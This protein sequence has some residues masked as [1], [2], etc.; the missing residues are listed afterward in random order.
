M[1]KVAARKPAVAREA[2]RVRVDHHLEEPEDS[3]GDGAIPWLR[4]DGV[5]TNGAAAK[6]TK[7][8]PLSKNMKFAVAPLVLTPFVPFRIPWESF[9]AD[10]LTLIRG[11]RMALKNPAPNLSFWAKPQ[12]FLHRSH[13]E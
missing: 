10:A 6:V 11:R 4:T 12:E 13:N 1:R 9:R 8:Q 5:N 2:G 3:A 7:K